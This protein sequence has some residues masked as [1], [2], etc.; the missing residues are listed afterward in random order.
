MSTAVAR[1]L[2]LAGIS[3][4]ATRVSGEQLERA[5]E[6]AFALGQEIGAEQAKAA[7]EAA[8]EEAVAAARER[9]SAILSSPEAV[10]RRDLAMKLAFETDMPASIAIAALK[11]VPA[12][13]T[14]RRSRLDGNIPN[15]MIEV[16]FDPADVMRA[17]EDLRSTGLNA[18]I[19]RQLALRKPKDTI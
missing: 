4:D 14:P 7:A 15:P 1:V 8:A 16:G 18:A 10:G 2:E 19:D 17:G 5:R 13:I 12:V 11:I 6:I 9:Q 3:Q